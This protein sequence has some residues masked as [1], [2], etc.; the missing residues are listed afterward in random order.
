MQNRA[1]LGGLLGLLEAVVR[2][3]QEQGAALEPGIAQRRDEHLLD[4][5]S[6]PEAPAVEHQATETRGA[7]GGVHEA[8]PA[9]AASAVHAGDERARW[10]PTVL[11]QQLRQEPALEAPAP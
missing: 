6:A 8:R 10:P 2:V 11:P 1:Q 3:M 7:A 5:A 4:V 9:A